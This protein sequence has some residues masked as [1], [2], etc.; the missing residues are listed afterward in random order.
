MRHV[1]FLDHPRSRAKLCVLHK[2]HAG[3]LAS[4]LNDHNTW[5]YLMR[6]GPM[7]VEGEEKWISDMIESSARTPQSDYVFVLVSKHGNCPIGMMGLHRIDWKNRNAITGTF[8]GDKA[9][10]NRGLATDAKMLLLKW[11]FDELGLN[12][13]ES[14]VLAFNE[15][16]QAYSS[17]CGYEVVGKLKRQV[18]R[19]G[20]YHDEIIMEVHADAWRALWKKFETGEYHQSREAAEVGHDCQHRALST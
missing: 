5:K 9:Y 10:R 17:K 3:L 6:Y 7:M 16:S 12:K 1:T 4:W 13:V 2:S 20:T 11:A 8:I 18:W 15:R 19:D 14:R